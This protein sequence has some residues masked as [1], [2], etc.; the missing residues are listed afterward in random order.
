[1]LL[2]RANMFRFKLEV[3]ILLL[4]SFFFLQLSFGLSQGQYSPREN[5]YDDV[6]GEEYYNP[7]GS[8]PNIA[9]TFASPYEDQDAARYNE[10]P[11][12]Y[13][14]VPQY[15]PPPPQDPNVIIVPRLGKVR[16]KIGYKVIGNCAINSFLGLQYGTVRPGVGRF[17]VSELVLFLTLKDEV[18]TKYS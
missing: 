5:E 15:P 10:Q 11:P 9:A 18:R 12:V 14:P 1:M 17:Q 3:P 7:A 13:R 16:G 8:R 4:V 2:V 6:E